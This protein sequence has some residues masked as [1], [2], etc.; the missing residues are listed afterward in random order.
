MPIGF[1]KWQTAMRR[2]RSRA[3]KSRPETPQSW[4][5]SQIEAVRHR[6]NALKQSRR[7]NMFTDLFADNYRRNLEIELGYLIHFQTKGED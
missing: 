1:S 3:P 7:E 5:T 2:S 4:L 6:L